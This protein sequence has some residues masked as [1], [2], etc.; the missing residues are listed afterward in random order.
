MLHLFSFDDH[1]NCECQ[2]GYAGPFCEH[3]TCYANPCEHGST[4][5]P[6]LD[7]GYLCVCPYGKHGKNCEHG[8]VSFVLINIFYSL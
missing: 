7:S 8:N 2:E 5:L 3:K 1:W 4:C 6:S